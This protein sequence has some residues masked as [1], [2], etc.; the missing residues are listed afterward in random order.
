MLSP[1]GDRASGLG[2]EIPRL[3]PSIQVAVKGTGCREVPGPG[4]DPG[5]AESTQG[6]DREAVEPQS[7]RGLK[8]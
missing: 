3:A 2:R 6:R 4:K 1:C 8:R 7:Q 5:E